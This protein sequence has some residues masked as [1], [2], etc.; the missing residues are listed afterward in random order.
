MSESSPKHVVTK[1]QPRKKGS[2]SINPEG[3]R[4]VVGDE[5]LTVKQVSEKTGIPLSTLRKWYRDTKNGL[6]APSK[7]MIVGGIVI[8][9]YTEDDVEEVVNYRNRSK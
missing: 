1:R 9:L 3:V 7:Q 4:A 6:K 2:K 8:Y 5:Y